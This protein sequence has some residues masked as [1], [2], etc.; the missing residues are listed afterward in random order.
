MAKGQTYRPTAYRRKTQRQSRLG[1]AMGILLVIVLL[2]ASTSFYFYGSIPS[3]LVYSRVEP[4]LTSTKDFLDSLL[5]PPPPLPEPRFSFYKTI[6][7]AEITFGE[8]ELNMMKWKKL[9]VEKKPSYYF[10]QLGSFIRREEAEQLQS[11]MAALKI[12]GIL[13]MVQRDRITWYRVKLGPYGTSEDVEK[14]RSY[15]Y[16]HHID[17]I[18]QTPKIE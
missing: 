5:V 11:T 16:A 3:S 17:S 12:D 7:E 13:E 14:V 4:A 15:L 6:P 8:H 2:G 18:V 1:K 9:S 10:L